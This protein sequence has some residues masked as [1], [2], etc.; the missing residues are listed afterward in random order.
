MLEKGVSP[1]RISR[2][3]LFEEVAERLRARIF[4]HDLPPGSWIDEQAI[5]A[6]YGISRTP[7]REA[8]KV[9]ASEGLVT[10]TPGRGCNVTALTEQDLDEIFPILALLEGRCAFEAA[11]RMDAPAQQ[12]VRTLHETL[13]GHFTA[14]D[15]EAFFN[16]NQLFH[17][18]VQE[19][20]G[21]RW[22]TQLIQDVR[23]KL[24]LTRFHSL[25]RDGRLQ[26]SLEE[27]RAIVTALLEA[28]AP[29]AQAAMENHLLQGR[30]AMGRMSTR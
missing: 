30:R 5:T 12:R 8:L 29:A 17:L 1:Q 26:E 18:A 24:K 21:N 4:A 19:I 13:E 6:E 15:I 23:Q 14:G 9:L 25:F 2:T 11:A 3:A 7:L 20:A 10:L 28:N 22:L 27:H 16:T